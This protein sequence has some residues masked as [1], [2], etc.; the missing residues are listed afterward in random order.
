MKVIT[1]NRSGNLPQNI[2][3][4]TRT[5]K[6]SASC[7]HLSEWRSTPRSSHFVRFHPWTRKLLLE[8]LQQV[9]LFRLCPRCNPVVT[10]LCQPSCI[11]ASTNQEIELQHRRLHVQVLHG[12]R[13]STRPYSAAG[14]GARPSDVGERS[15]S[16]TIVIV[17]TW[18]CDPC[19]NHHLHF[20]CQSKCYVQK[21]TALPPANSNVHPIY[22][23]Q[24][25]CKGG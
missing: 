19:R 14:Q 5:V 24:C 9:V 23:F 25:R 13:Q 3:L 16:H 17:T 20:C 22:G 8:E 18:S 1:F 11:P 10:C 4:V 12:I 2:T 7:K 15:T 21:W 6:K